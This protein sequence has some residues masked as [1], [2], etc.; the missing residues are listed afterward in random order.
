M[1]SILG[2]LL[3]GD[4]D[5]KITCTACNSQL[6]VWLRNK[7]Q[8]SLLSGQAR[9]CAASL[10]ANTLNPAEQGYFNI[11]YLPVFFLLT[12]SKTSSQPR[13]FHNLNIKF[14]QLTKKF[15]SQF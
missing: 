14:P 4:C 1:S 3:S 13:H 12:L 7:I 8:S 15:N 5:T 11:L 2:Q 6:V 9:K 10:F